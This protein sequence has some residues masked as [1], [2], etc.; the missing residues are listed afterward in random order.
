[1][2]LKIIFN[3]RLL[4]TFT[5][6]KFRGKKSHL[7]L[8]LILL[9]LLHQTLKSHIH[10]DSRPST[11]YRVFMHRFLKLDSFF[12]LQNQVLSVLKLTSLHFGSS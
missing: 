1:M 4:A 9:D 11:S 5:Q 2:I 3:K 12:P 7:P 8:Y 10:C 6:G